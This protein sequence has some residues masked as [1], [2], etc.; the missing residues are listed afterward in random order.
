MFHFLNVSQFFYFSHADFSPVGPAA[1]FLTYYP[2]K[3]TFICF[4][5]QFKILKYST[6]LLF[7]FFRCNHI[8]VL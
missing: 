7:S 1:Q 8:P 2:N 6:A 5:V 3:A 4:H